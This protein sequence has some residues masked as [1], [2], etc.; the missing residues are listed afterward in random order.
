MAIE[1]SKVYKIRTE[2]AENISEATIKMIVETK[3][4][5]KESDVLHA[6]IKKFLPLLKSQDV[7]N[8]RQE[9]LGKD[10]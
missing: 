3:I 6:L 7:V 2:E 1:M 8:Y 10:D 4:H 9:I 5:V